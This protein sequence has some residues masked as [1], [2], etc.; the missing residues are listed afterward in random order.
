MPML[1]FN[2][3]REL[4][5]QIANEPNSPKLVPLFAKLRKLLAELQVS[6]NKVER[7]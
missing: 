3:I 1:P 2:E 6:T 7:H 4:C 5:A